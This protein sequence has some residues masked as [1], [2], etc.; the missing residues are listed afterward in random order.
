MFVHFFLEV[1]TS[2]EGL[3]S[4]NF[5]SVSRLQFQHEKSMFL[6][7][8]PPKR[9]REDE[10]MKFITVWRLFWLRLFYVVFVF[11]FSF[12][13]DLCKNFGLLDSRLVIRRSFW[14]VQFDSYSCGLLV[15]A[16]WMMLDP[17]TG[18]PRQR[19]RER[20][21]KNIA[22]IKISRT[23]AHYVLNG[24]RFTHSGAFDSINEQMP[25]YQV[26]IQHVSIETI[27]ESERTW[28]KPENKKNQYNFSIGSPEMGCINHQKWW[29]VMALFY[30][31]YQHYNHRKFDTQRS[32]QAIFQGVLR[33]DQWKRSRC[34]VRARWNFS[35]KMDR[36]SKSTGSTNKMAI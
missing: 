15:D 19:E 36:L 9:E 22:I 32:Q 10:E 13:L 6:G 33:G 25:T 24:F 8:Q 35:M 16:C 11:C 34:T 1:Y 5:A 21:I 26:P 27:F 4:S 3:P 31:H 23:F 2:F 18:P 12:S 29:V 28:Q 14:M 7:C 20:E 30:P 17:Y